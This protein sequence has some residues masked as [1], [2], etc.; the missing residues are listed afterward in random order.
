MGGTDFSVEGVIDKAARFQQIW[1]MSGPMQDISETMATLGTTAA[2]IDGIRRASRG[3][4][5]K[6]G[7]MY[8][9]QMGIDPESKMA[10]RI[11]KQFEDHG[12][13]INGSYVANS[14][15]W[16]DLE[17]K[18]FFDTAVWSDVKAT[19]F[20]GPDIASWPM[21]LG[22]PRGNIRFITKFMGYSFTAVNNF[23]IPLA[24]SLQRGDMHRLSTA[25]VLVAISSLV[26]PLRK[27]G[28]GEEPD[29]DPTNMLM[30]GIANSGI[31]GAYLDVILRANAMANFIPTAKADRFR[32]TRGLMNSGPEA[33][34]TDLA[35]IIGMAATGDI[36]KNDLNRS[37]KLFLPFTDI[38]PLRAL[39]YQAVEDLEIPQRRS[40]DASDFLP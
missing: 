37:A 2:I 36:N 31:L 4:L 24:Q 35:K 17:A 30:G 40:K 22:D 8:L 13:R 33:L 38:Y 11:L 6:S 5:S 39:R 15:N 26:E 19:I 28:R 12:Q 23:L 21:W 9:A 1:N 3:K 14:G 27:I 34:L 20:S 32:Y 29:L 16:K 10:A 25:A 7:R 18:R